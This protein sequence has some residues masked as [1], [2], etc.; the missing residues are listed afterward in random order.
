MGFYDVL[1]Q[2]LDL[3]R[4]RGRVTYRALKREF[5]LD[6]AF[7]EDLKEEPS[8]A[9]NWPRMKMAESSSGPAP[10]PTPPHQPQYPLVPRHLRP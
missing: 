10:H 5:Q 1:E 8:T 2:I 6:D 9:S 7:L 3:L 4:R